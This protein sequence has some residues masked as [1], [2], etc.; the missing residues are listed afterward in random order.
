MSASYPN[1]F[2][3][4][5]LEH[6]IKRNLFSFSQKIIKKKP[7]KVP[8]GHPISHIV[9]IDVNDNSDCFPNSGL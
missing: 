5:S 7:K 6:P 9:V 8:G 4:F 2:S 3:H 1:L